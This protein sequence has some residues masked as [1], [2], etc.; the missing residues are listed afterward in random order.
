MIR[1]G[2]R[3]ATSGGRGALVGLA[4]AAVAVAT[5]TAVLLF[6]LSFKPAL[7]DRAERAAWRSS[8][9]ISDSGTAADAALLVASNVDEYQGQPLERVLVARLVDDPPLPPGLS[10][11]PGPGESLVSPSLA[12]LIAA[13]PADQLGDRFGTVVGTIGDAALRSP[14]ELVAVV[15]MTPE[16]L[17]VLGAAPVIGFDPTPK[18][19]DIPAIAILLIVLAIIGA[20]VPVAVFVSTAT[21]L[22]AARREQRLAALRLIGATAFQVTRLAAVEAMVVSVIGVVVGIGLFV[23]VRPLVAL[24]PLDDATWFADSIQPPLVPAILLLL[25]IPVVGAAAAVV[26]LRRVVVTPLGVQRRQTPASPG[27]ARAVPLVIALVALASVSTTAGRFVSGDPATLL[28]MG[29]S[30]GGVIVGIVLIGPWLTVLVGRALR[31]LPGGAS[32]LLASRRLTDDPRGSFGAIAGVIMAVFVASAFFTFVGF[33]ANQGSD[34]GGVVGPNQVFVE[35]PFNE[36]PPFAEVPA[37]IAAVP[38]VRSVLPIPSGEVFDDGAPV[39]AWVVTCADFVRQFALPA[40]GCGSAPIHILDGVTTFA[41]GSYTFSPDRG[42]RAAIDV[43]IKARDVASFNVGGGIVIGRLPQMIIDPSLIK[44]A[45]HQASPTRFYVTTDGSSATGERV[46]TAVMASV[47]TAYVRLADEDRSTSHVYE[48]FGRVV[49]LGL[50]G[51]LI[52]AGCSLAVSVTTSVLE[53]RR[54]FALLRSAGMP[55][56]RLRAVVLLQ[57]GA[58]LVVVAIFSAVLGIVVAQVILRLAEATN[59]PWPNASLAVVLAVSLAAALGVVALMLPPLERLTRPDSV[60][61]E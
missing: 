26:A 48:E 61:V 29:V 21:R 22:S 45:A 46:R 52:L 25:A 3:L 38:G 30:F 7:D 35:M 2:I 51:S 55:V 9:V 32:M 11:L 44:A 5:G 47:P 16:A 57:A 58:P 27:F 49:A 15:G 18:P 13:V 54:Q 8:F 23:L 31:W 33:A 36:G 50:V 10:R 12:A 1:L 14:Q 42:D 59:V 28:K 40:Q 53:R 20:L 4:L 34:R 39:E 37:R 6:A 24:V 60:R 43:T 19:P 56:S 17:D 41:A